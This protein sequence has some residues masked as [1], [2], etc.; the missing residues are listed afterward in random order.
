MLVTLSVGHLVSKANQAL[1]T[2]DYCFTPAEILESA[3]HCINGDIDC[4]MGNLFRDVN[5]MD[6][7]FA[8]LPYDTPS[9]L[10][11]KDVIK[12]VSREINTTLYRLCNGIMLP[13]FVN[14]GQHHLTLTL[15]E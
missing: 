4:A 5:Q 14:A 1:Q 7:S 9:D 12:S 6:D 15:E 8:N 11:L 13:R 10:V 2:S 3:V